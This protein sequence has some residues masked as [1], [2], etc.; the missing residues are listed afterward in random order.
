[1]HEPSLP[2][3]DDYRHSPEL[4]HLALLE[5]TLRTTCRALVGDDTVPALEQDY[6][7]PWRLPATA[8]GWVR[9][10]LL[11]SA[12]TLAEAIMAYRHAVSRREQRQLRLLPDADQ[13]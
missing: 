2:G 3:P 13:R 7:P 1:M 11:A 4:A 9:Y 12:D 8:E 10:W 5:V 6:V